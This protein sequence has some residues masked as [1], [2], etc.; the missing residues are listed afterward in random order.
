MYY[1]TIVLLSYNVLSIL[2]VELTFSVWR[3]TLARDNEV[4][5][6]KKSKEE[7]NVGLPNN[8]GKYEGKSRDQISH[9]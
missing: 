5:S 4:R 7:R 3:D 6:P 9:G 8:D 2:R 1:N